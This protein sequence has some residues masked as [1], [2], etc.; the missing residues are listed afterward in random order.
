MTGLYDFPLA[1]LGRGVPYYDFVLRLPGKMIQAN[2]TLLKSD[3]WFTVVAGFAV[4]NLVSFL[5]RTP[6]VQ[7]PSHRVYEP[8]H[9]LFLWTIGL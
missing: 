7:G 4:A 2:G 9:R 1:F 5:A 8:P 6:C 3:V